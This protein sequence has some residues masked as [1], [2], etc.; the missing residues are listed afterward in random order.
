MSIAVVS[1]MIATFP[2]GGVAWDYG[3]YALGLERLGFD[4]YYLED[5]G[6]PGYDVDRGEY[7]NDLT[8]GVKF[9][10]QALGALSP[11]LADRCH[12][13]DLDDHTYG[14]E[15]ADF[16]EI[17]AAAD[18]FLNVSGGTQLR[19]EYVAA[20]RKVLIDTDPGWNHF[21]IWPRNEENTRRGLI[22]SFRE[23]DYFFTYAERIG[24]SDCSLPS[25]GIE[26][27]PTRMPVV[28]DCWGPQPPGSTWT[29]VLSWDNYGAPVEHDCERYGSKADEFASIESLPQRVNVP[30]QIAAGGVRPPV[31]RWRALGWSVVDS[32]ATTLSL[33]DYRSYVQSSRG[34][35]S[36][37]KNIY[38]ATG[39]GWFS[40]RSA[41]YL[42]AGRPVV[43]QDT[44]YSK[45][46]PSDEGLIAFT[47][48]DSAIDALDRV[49]SDYKAHAAAARA[50]ARDHLDHEKVLGD[51]LARVG[52]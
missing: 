24:H 14:I 18:V 29:T 50:V 52:L 23:H 11:S 44:G 48:L 51:L 8:N 3:Q 12:V 45:V 17:M 10:E 40:C 2:V 49:E 39:S 6:A 46:L 31:D 5:V 38:R 43:L 30:L 15:G 33:D 28:T 41:C 20:K 27:F 35:F 34:E 47:D 22:R 4:V 19:D 32:V 1:G 36:V 42:A 16:V 37:A 25:L 13:R 26:W 21:V 9:L 7:T